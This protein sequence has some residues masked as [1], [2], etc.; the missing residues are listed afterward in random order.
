MDQIKL[1]YQQRDRTLTIWFA[2]EVSD[3][4][5]EQAG[6]EVIVLKDARDAVVG[7]QK[8]NFNGDPHQ[9]NVSFSAVSG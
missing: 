2:G 5:R 3:T 6:P 7:V 4:S 1:L 9:L 8:L